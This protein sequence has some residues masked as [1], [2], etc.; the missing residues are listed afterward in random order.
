MNNNIKF[1][2]SFERIEKDFKDKKDGLIQDYFEELWYANEGE[3]FSTNH[4]HICQFELEQK[5]FHKKDKGW[6]KRK[7]KKHLKLLGVTR[8][9]DRWCCDICENGR[10]CKY[11]KT[12]HKGINGEIL[13]VE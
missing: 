2:W 7:C 13:F 5:L 12:F 3:S 4:F 6:A 1:P 9:K 11:M 10:S 8:D